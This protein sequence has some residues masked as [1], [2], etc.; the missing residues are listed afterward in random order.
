MVPPQDIPDGKPRRI[1]D[2]LFNT[3][4]PIS[5]DG[6]TLA[7][8][9]NDKIVLLPAEGGPARPLPGSEAGDLLIRWSGDGNALF[10]QHGFAPASVFRL[11]VATGK[12][13]LVRTLAP[14]DPAGVEGINPIQLTPDGTTYVYTTARV[15]SDLYMAEG[16]R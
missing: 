10:I 11:E 3:E 14:A 6:K 13:T 15:L 7:V 5:P 9:Q 1:G 16:L 4:H 2:G 8:R 12:R